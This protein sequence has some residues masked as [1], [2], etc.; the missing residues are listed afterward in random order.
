MDLSKVKWVF[1]AVVVLG[2]GWLVTEGGI[3]WMYN[4]ATAATP[5][6]NEARD[7]TDEMTL[8]RYGGFLL[9]TFRYEDAKR[10][11]TAAINRYP[12]GENRY[13]NRF[14]LARVEEKLGN[15]QAAIDLLYSLYE[16]D[17]DQFDER[18]DS[19]QQLQL[20]IQR[21]AEVNDLP[22]PI[23]QYARF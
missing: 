6:E 15:Y 13:Y 16:I 7:K 21:I 9:Q 17:A 2:V 18:V 1:I 4:R 20:R 23:D 14:Q 8:T 3:E 19:R 22:N 5:G 12:A 10:F 11:Y